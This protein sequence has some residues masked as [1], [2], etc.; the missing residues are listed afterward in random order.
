MQSSSRWT[1]EA[2]PNSGLT[3]LAL[4][5]MQ[6]FS[7]ELRH[8]PTLP[9]RTARRCLTLASAFLRQHEPAMSIPA[10]ANNILHYVMQRSQLLGY[11]DIMPSRYGKCTMTCTEKMHAH[12]T[13]LHH[14]WL[15]G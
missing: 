13:E 6:L 5:G 15:E 3:T 9:S 1:E 7:L 4:Q 11:M 2:A 12:F 10:D 14:V 8:W